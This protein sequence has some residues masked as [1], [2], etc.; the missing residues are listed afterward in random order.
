MALGASDREV[1]SMVL[2]QAATLAGIGGIIGLVLAGGVG[3]LAQSLLVGVAPIDPISF[4][5][6]AVLFL[7][8]L[9]AA[10]WAPA[11]RAASTDPAVALRAE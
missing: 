5:A 1:R 7:I 8:V 4:G 6:T 3:T 2:Q 9:A 10:A 11:T